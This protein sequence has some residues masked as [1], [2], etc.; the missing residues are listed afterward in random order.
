MKQVGIEEPYLGYLRDHR[1]EA[2]FHD[3]FELLRYVNET[4]KT[5]GF[6]YSVF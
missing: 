2:M 5:K 6:E 4:L 1:P 3:K